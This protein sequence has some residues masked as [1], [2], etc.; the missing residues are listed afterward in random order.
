MNVYLDPQAAELAAH[1]KK[2]GLGAR[3]IASH[4]PGRKINASKL[5]TN[6]RL[7]AAF[8]SKFKT[9]QLMLIRT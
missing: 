9:G 1:R 4:Q 7:K 3:K 2:Y 8:V 5:P 6:I